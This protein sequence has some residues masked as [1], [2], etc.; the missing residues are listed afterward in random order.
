MTT[1][2]DKPNSSICHYFVDE[3][4][5]PVLFSRRKEIIIDREGCSS[6]FILGL[7]DIA[8]PEFLDSE[9]TS[10][11]F[12][13]LADPY[14]KRVPSMQPSA[15][16]TALTFHAKDDVQEV[17]REVF[18]LL[19]QHEMR[20]FAV[21]RDKRQVLSYVCQRNERDTNYRYSPN[22]LYDSL[23]SRLF[24]DRLHKE[25]EYNIYFAKRG[26]SDRTIALRTALEKARQNFQQKW[27]ITSNASTNVIA[28][29]PQRCSGLQAADYFL[30]AL[31]RLYERGEDRYL[32]FVWSR[33]S[34]VHDIDDTSTAKYGVYYTQKNPLTVAKLTKK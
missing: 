8:N 29:T 14:F 20:F 5:D 21:V 3:A 34:L 1:N 7:L 9:L 12:R 33:V 22:E 17:R 15:R 25:D 11:R 19:M 2:N 18:S 28:N 6:Y 24:R 30:W 13:L 23:V 26:T 10:L 31:Q 4:G 32:E 16:K 27:N